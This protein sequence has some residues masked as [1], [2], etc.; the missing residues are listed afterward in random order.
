[1]SRIS[2]LGER[3]RA[4]ALYNTLTPEQKEEIPQVLRV[5]LRYR[6]EKYFGEHRSPPKGK[7]GH[8]SK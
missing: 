3:D 8:K 7:S 2:F 4:L 5:W 6:S 1:M